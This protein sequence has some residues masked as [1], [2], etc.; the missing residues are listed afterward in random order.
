MLNAAEKENPFYKLDETSDILSNIISTIGKIRTDASIKKSVTLFR[1]LRDNIQYIED[2]VLHYNKDNLILLKDEINNVVGSSKKMSKIMDSQLTAFIKVNFDAEI[3][4][5]LIENKQSFDKGL[6]RYKRYYLENENIYREAHKQPLDTIPLLSE[7][8]NIVFFIYCHGESVYD[9]T[10]NKF[11]NIIQPRFI[12]II[13]KYTAA[14]LCETF[15]SSSMQDKYA[16]LFI[17]I[18]DNHYKSI[19]INIFDNFTYLILI[20]NYII[21]TL[22]GEYKDICTKF[23]N[24]PIKDPTKKANLE[25]I[26]DSFTPIIEAYIN[27]NPQLYSYPISNPTNHRFF[28]NFDEL[29]DAIKKNSIHEDDLISPCRVSHT[30]INRGDNPEKI[31]D[32][33]DKYYSFENDLSDPS[34]LDIKILNTFR[35][36]FDDIDHIVV[37]GDSFAELLFILNN[38]GKSREM[39][40]IIKKYKNF[41]G[42]TIDPREC[43]FTQSIM[44]SAIN[45]GLKK[46]ISSVSLQFLLFFSEEIGAHKTSFFDFSCCTAA[47]TCEGDELDPSLVD[48]LKESG[49]TQP[50]LSQSMFEENIEEPLT[51][52]E[53]RESIEEERESIEEPDTLEEE[54][55]V[56]GG[57]HSKNTQRCKNKNKNM[58]RTKRHNNTRRLRRQRTSNRKNKLTRRRNK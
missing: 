15:I 12:N 7:I 43:D 40:K 33:R 22:Y 32:I 50:P 47:L 56:F 18:L 13:L 23:Q 55:M 2:N 30:R 48:I 6:N 54:E 37:A 11:K 19:G 36:V 49:P 14:S 41:R 8:G 42:E 35:F 26:Y 9:E 16:V 38:D 28:D 4:D 20:S 25:R 39:K 58:T 10:T 51:L 17:I 1:N 53:E 21:L 31:K 27:D 29:I 46:T 3:Y 57:A 5:E 44:R 45:V 24:I 52:E 34:S